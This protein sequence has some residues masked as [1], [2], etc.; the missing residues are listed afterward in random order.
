[1]WDR[2]PLQW[3]YVYVEK[4]PR[5]PAGPALTDGK[6]VH[7]GIA[8]YL[9]G[10]S[11][12]DSISRE[13]AVYDDPDERE[14]HQ[15]SVRHMVENVISSIR[16]REFDV[17]GIEK[18]VSGVGFLGYVDCLAK[19]DGIPTMID[20]K[21]TNKPYD[22]KLVDGHNQLTAYA[23]LLQP[24]TYRL[25]YVTI[26]KG[27][28]DVEWWFTNRTPDQIR[29]YQEKVNV[30]RIEMEKGNYHAKDGWHCGWCDFQ[31]ICEEKADF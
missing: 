21:T 8:S 18:R 9:A 1:M 30:T 24:E 27:V 28:N 19:V 6:A 12:K 2:C 25:C 7:A 11:W 4:F 20:W 26:L 5:G 17:I 15:V 3:S 10:K 22:Q 16:K 13:L 23:W 14:Y 31:D 29:D